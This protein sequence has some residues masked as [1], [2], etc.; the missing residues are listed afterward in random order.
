MVGQDVCKF[1]KFGGPEKRKGRRGGVAVACEKVQRRLERAHDVCEQG[2]N[3][4]ALVHVRRQLGKFCCTVGR[5]ERP[6]EKQ[7]GRIYC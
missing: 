2:Q 4:Q 6:Y 3:G 1:E 5:I 7:E